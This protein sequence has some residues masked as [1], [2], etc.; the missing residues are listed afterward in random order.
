MPKAVVPKCSTAPT[1]PI[2]SRSVKI[3]A[4]LA[5][6]VSFGLL[7]G[8]T[9]VAAATSPMAS[10]GAGDFRWTAVDGGIGM[11]PRLLTFTSVGRLW[12]CVGVPG[13]TGGTFTGVHEATSDCMHPADG[14]ITVDILWSNG[15]TSTLA[16][17]WPVGMAQPTVGPLDIVRGIGQGGR[18]RVVAEY[19]MMT[20]D[21]VMGCMGP[22]VTTGPGRVSASMA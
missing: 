21:M 14:P 6:S 15:D 3:A 7:P 4:S 13:I 16:G 8:G 22:G 18:V 10:C 1:S 12:D 9:P 11:S 2:G 5:I 20:P 19:E 17:P